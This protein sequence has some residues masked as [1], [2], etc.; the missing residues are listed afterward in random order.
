MIIQVPNG[1]GALLGLAQLILYATFYRSTKRMLAQRGAQRE[2]G[3]PTPQPVP[4]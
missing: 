3:L 4:V 2:V 1:L